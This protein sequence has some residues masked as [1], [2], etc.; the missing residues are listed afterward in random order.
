GAATVLAVVLVSHLIASR[1]S[2]N[3]ALLGGAVQRLAG[4]EFSAIALPRWD[5][6][7]RDL[8]QA[9]NKTADRLREYQQELRQTE[10]LRTISMLGAGLAHELRNAAT[11]CRMAVDL[12]AESCPTASQDE[13]IEVARRQL[14]LMESRLQQLLQL[15]NRPG[16]S[17]EMQADLR[18]IVSESIELIL[19]AAR[20]AGVRVDWRRPT[21]A[22]PVLGDPMLLSEVIMNL[23]LNA[24][25]AAAKRQ[26]GGGPPG[27]VRVELARLGADEV[28]TV[29]DSG[30][31]PEG[32]IGA[33]LFQPFVTSKPE[34]VGLGLA[35]AKQIVT[36]LGGD[37]DWRRVKDRTEF[38][39][40]IPTA[41]K[42]EA[43]VKHPGR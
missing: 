32:A 37:I 41:D 4:G 1:L 25:D 7:T 28:L 14:Q 33:N 15:G 3:L 10:Q 42:G 2:R 20:H 23:L 13:S 19:P 31:G 24:L 43:S 17:G 21:D 11:G 9:I 39:I 12:H 35:V 18:G 30:S 34:G 5:D 22:H 29:S 36:S 27:D 16:P 38:R 26:A 8:T 40:R 6:E